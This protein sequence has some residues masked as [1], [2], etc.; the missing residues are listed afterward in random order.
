MI[1]FISTM[2]ALVGCSKEAEQPLTSNEL[3]HFPLDS[4]EGIISQTGVSVD[5]DI[6]N[7]GKGSLR[8]RVE[9]PSTVRLFEVSGVDVEDSQLLYRA[10]VRTE[11]FKGQVYLEMWVNLPGKGEFFTRNVH[12]P[13][14]G[15]A[16]WT[17]MIAPFFLKKGQNPDYV[18]L[19]LVMDGAGTAWIDDIRLV[20]G[21]LK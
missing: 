4:M 21:P 9:E 3:R 13:L 18:K 10:R 1:F 2:L 6:S 11:D 14:S 19:N 12:T 16:N 15:T 7:D 20:K 17:T 5:R 8:I